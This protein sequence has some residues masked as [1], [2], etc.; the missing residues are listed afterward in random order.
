MKRLIVVVFVMG[1]VV[2]RDPFFLNKVHQKIRYILKGTLTGPEPIACIEYKGQLYN[3]LCV[4]DTVGKCTVT[5]IRCGAVYL[6]H[7]D[8]HIEVLQLD[9]DKKVGEY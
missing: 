7:A 9:E 6:R 4:N 1:V 3:N 5:K 2:A 8:G